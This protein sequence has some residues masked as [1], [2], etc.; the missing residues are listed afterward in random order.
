M[1][2]T[3]KCENYDSDDDNNEDDQ[4][5]IKDDNRDDGDADFDKVSNIVMVLN[6]YDMDDDNND[7]DDKDQVDIKD[8][9]DDYYGRDL[10]KALNREILGLVAHG[11]SHIQVNY[12]VVFNWPPLKS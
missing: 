2:W 6:I 4:V 10:A 8:D 11:C 5:E 3:D 12:R 9:G 1:S 7:E